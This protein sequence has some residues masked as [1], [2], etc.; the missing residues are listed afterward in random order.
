MSEYRRI[1]TE[2]FKLAKPNKLWA[3]FAFLTLLLAQSC[4]LV[5]PVFIAKITIALTSG[6]YTTGIIFLIAVF[7]LL[8]LRRTFLH[9]N[10]LIYTNLIKHS[11][12]YLNG[13]II[14]KSLNAKAKNFKCVSKEHILNTT[15]TDVFTISEL[16]DKLATASARGIILIVT[17]AI[18]FS[19]NFIAG[20]IVVFA[21]ILNYFVLG[22]L[23]KKRSVHVKNI[24]RDHDSQYEKVGEIVDTRT[25]IKDFGIENKFKKD[26]NKILGSYS[27]NLKKRLF[28][29]SM[30][31][32]YYN[33]F[34]SLI[35]LVATIFMVLLVS[36]NALSIE[37]YF[38]IVA[39]ITSGIEDTN[40]IYNIIPNIRATEI[41]SERVKTVLNFIENE[42]FQLDKINLKDILGRVYF[43]H[44]YYNYDEDG[45]PSLT[46]F[47]AFLKENETCL[48]LGVKNCG[49]RTIF[50]LFRRAIKPTKG[51]IFIDGV[52]IFDYTK[53]SYR[54]NIC[55]VT[56]KPTFFRG[57]I[58]KN[59]TFIEKNKKII[60][61]LCKEVGIYDYI[62][63]L[64]K[65]FNT[66]V[67]ALPY[68]IIYQLALVR[69]I[70]TGAE[71]MIIYEFPNNLNETEKAN[72]I[73]ILDKLH[74]TRTIII[75]SAQ[76]Y[77]SVLA[78]KII[79]IEKGQSKITFNKTEN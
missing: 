7:G 34:Y 8:V 40:N 56:T 29:D 21:D 23:N 26:F 28:W 9:C 5:A 49:K 39:F 4:L 69:A 22:W 68:E 53:N 11:Y 61:L 58:I 74:G 57:S 50:N 66:D 70:S 1:I 14:N 25:S 31:D 41:A 60:N 13:E 55:Y 54:D 79:E 73:N 44:V 75:F 52:N 36:G 72:I 46:D 24:R 18:I 45:N 78:D 62:M 20:L 48:I 77:C 2:W 63:Q 19:V 51:N 10:Y 42:N 15:H 37:T 64:P 71:I 33:V 32:N 30:V 27:N 12:D 16:A 59:L 38:V 3:W 17:I 35:I 76:E 43:S 47:D 67:S 65:K 6:E